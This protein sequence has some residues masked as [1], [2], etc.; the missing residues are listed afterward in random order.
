MKASITAQ[1]LT[2]PVLAS[3]MVST[4]AHLQNLG[5]SSDLIPRDEARRL[6][7]ELLGLGENANIEEAKVAYR[8]K[9]RELHPDKA[10]AP[11]ESAR[12][13]MSSDF[14]A[15]KDCNEWLQETSNHAFSDIGRPNHTSPAASVPSE[16]RN[17]AHERFDFA[18]WFADNAA[19]R[20]SEFEQERA[21]F[22]R[23]Q[24]KREQELEELLQKLR[25]RERQSD[26]ADVPHEADVTDAAEEFKTDEER[27]ARMTPEERGAEDDLY[28]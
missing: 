27:R 7:L 17:A 24:E 13:R 11:D 20:R 26:E 14:L 25:N 22:K 6:C 5:L 2:Q 4:K 18:K 9:A 3:W 1:L 28:K 19:M 23:R 12:R 21:E 8:A 10:Q 16:S 15:V